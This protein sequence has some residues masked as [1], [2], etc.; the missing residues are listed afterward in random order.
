ME[1]R[2]RRARWRRAW[3]WVADAD[4]AREHGQFGP[5]DKAN[6]SYFSD[7]VYLAPYPGSTG[8]IAAAIPLDPSLQLQVAFAQYA[9]FKD[10]QAQRTCPDPDVPRSSLAPG[11]G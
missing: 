10:P 4:H 7:Y 11:H 9:V 2:Y 8:V 3:D 6:A 5:A 1:R